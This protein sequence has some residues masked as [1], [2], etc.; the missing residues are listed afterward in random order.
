MTR[1]RGVFGEGAA[2]IVS[3]RTLQLF[4]SGTFC[5]RH[6][7]GYVGRIVPVCSAPREER[8]GLFWANVLHSNIRG[9]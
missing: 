6:Q 4:I 7:E 3:G 9:T 1:Q 8:S 5:T 2:D